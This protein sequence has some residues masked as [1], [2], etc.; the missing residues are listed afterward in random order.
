MQSHATLGNRLMRSR[1]FAL[2]AAA[3]SERAA[4][5]PFERSAAEV[6]I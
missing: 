1:F 6:S 3:A 5:G 4:R 2:D